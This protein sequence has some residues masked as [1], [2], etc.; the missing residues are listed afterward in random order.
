[1]GLPRGHTPQRSIIYLQE[2]QL[3]RG[4][5]A[6]DVQGLVTGP[7]HKEPVEKPSWSLLTQIKLGTLFWSPTRDI[8][9]PHDMSWQ[10]F[11]TDPI[12][13]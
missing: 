8:L 13:G 9:C 12:R 4:I 2:V 6:N 5:A 1:M 11:S 3:S 10:R 7:R